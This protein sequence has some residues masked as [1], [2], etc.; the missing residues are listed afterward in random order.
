MTHPTRPKLVRIRCEE[1][2]F[3]T[4]SYLFFFIY[5]EKI[6]LIPAEGGQKEKPC[7]PGTPTWEKKKNSPGVSPP[8]RTLLPQDSTPNQLMN[9]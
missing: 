5:F 4:L 6:T 1:T 2:R 3:L 9:G 7:V 8:C